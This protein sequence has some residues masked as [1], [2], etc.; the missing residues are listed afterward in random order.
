MQWSFFCPN[1]YQKVWFACQFTYIPGAVW[2]LLGCKEVASGKC[3]RSLRLTQHLKAACSLGTRVQTRVLEGIS[4]E[5]DARPGHRTVNS[6]PASV[7]PGLLLMWREP[8]QQKMALVCQTMFAIFPSGQPNLWQDCIWMFPSFYGLEW[9][10]EGCPGSLGSGIKLPKFI[11]L[12]W[13]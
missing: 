2:K 5:A 13:W 11:F 1:S 12:C 9:R 4:S 10:A 8:V 6:V 3:W 7:S